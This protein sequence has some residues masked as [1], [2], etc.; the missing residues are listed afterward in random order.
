MRKLRFLCGI[1]EIALFL[2]LSHVDPVHFKSISFWEKL[3]DSELS[4]SESEPLIAEEKTLIIS[5]RHFWR[6]WVERI[7]YLDEQIWIE[8][9][10]AI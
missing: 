9:I 7:R 1:Y 3:I 6:W 2:E 10:V 4:C 5:W 8:P